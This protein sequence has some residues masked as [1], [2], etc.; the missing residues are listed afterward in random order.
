MAGRGKQAGGG[1]LSRMISSVR[2][3]FV[4]LFLISAFINLL[5]LVT[6]LYMLQIYDRV[7]TSGSRETLLSLTVIA[8]FALTIFGVLEAARTMSLNRLGGWL[9]R[10]LGPSVLGASLNQ[11]ESAGGAQNGLRDLTSI[12][13]FIGGSG[14]T[15]FFDAPWTPVFIAIL[16]LLHP[17]FGIMALCTAAVLLAIAVVNEIS[18]RKSGQEG[19]ARREAVNRETDR[20][21]DESST[22]LALGMERAMIER[23]S[24]KSE[25]AGESESRAASINAALQGLAKSLR[26]FAQV[27]VLGI[28]AVLVLRGELSAGAMIAGSI[29]LGRAMAPV[30]QSIAAWRGF[31]SARLS[32]SRLKSLLEREP[33]KTD[34]VEVPQVRGALEVNRLWVRGAEAEQFILQNIEFAVPA[35]EAIAVVG[36]SGSGKSTLCRAICGVVTPARGEVR[37]D[38]AQISHWPREQFAGAIGYLP[39]SV[40]L[41]DGTVRDNIARMGEAGDEAVVEAA[42]Q[43]DVHALIQR[44]PDG[45]NTIVGPR[46]AKLSGGQ[47][48]RIGLARALFG[49]PSLV[50]LDEPNAN[51]DQVGEVALGAAIQQLKARGATVILVAHRVG[52]LSSVDRILALNAGQVDLYDSRDAV[53][54]IMKQRQRFAQDRADHPGGP[55]AAGGHAR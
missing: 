30:D 8:A 32:Y 38:G 51:L 36:P 7:L 19:A 46:G 52:A 40:E 26:L 42:R 39:Q 43:A 18:T 47:R 3:A 10:R 24:A 17:W 27:G 55:E 28:G 53:I 33:E 11:S 6:P 34:Q 29:L 45:Y 2:P 23:W 9:R 50:V 49:S 35:G 1:D 48:Q 4:V 22:V 5:H 37:V 13:G 21:I 20:I 15:P 44:L 54:S 12:Q 25:T 14:V 41:F 31:L 16:W